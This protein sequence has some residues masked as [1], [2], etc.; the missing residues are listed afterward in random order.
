MTPA[1]KNAPAKLRATVQPAGRR[2][3]APN[4]LSVSNGTSGR[5]TVGKVYCT[6]CTRTVDAAI[7]PVTTAFGQRRLAAQPRQKCPHCSS[8]LDAAFVLGNAA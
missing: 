4:G 8:S 5:N 3:V 6:L 1:S 7:V 2:A